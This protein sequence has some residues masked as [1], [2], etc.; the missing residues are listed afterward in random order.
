MPNVTTITFCLS[1]HGLLHNKSAM[2]GSLQEDSSPFKG[3]SR[4][5]LETSLHAHSQLS[6]SSSKPGL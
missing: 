1:Y 4:T 3:N 5:E 6:L 2:S